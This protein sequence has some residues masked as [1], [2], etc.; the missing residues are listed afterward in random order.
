M[1]AGF[2]ASL[3][4]VTVAEFGD[5]TFCAA[6]VLA[7]RYPRRWV[8]LGAWSAL[9]CMSVLAVVIGQLL[10]TVVPLLWIRLLSAA[11]FAL[12]GGQQLWQAWRAHQEDEMAEA[13]EALDNA[14]LAGA[15]PRWQIVR[16]TFTLIA[17]SE[18]GDKTQLATASLAAIHPPLSVFFGSSFGFALM[19]GAGVLGGRF[20]SAHIP[21]RLVEWLSGALFLGFAALTL[22]QAL[23]PG[24]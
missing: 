3:V 17:V 6:L 20:L 5:K 2:V 23:T 22:W 14:G 7:M 18:L 24:T 21:E 11:L 9:V 15:K 12:F 19:I 8:F 16:D 10:F 4:L 13:C 1:E